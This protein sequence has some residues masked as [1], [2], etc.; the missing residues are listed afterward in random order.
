MLLS[1]CHSEYIQH[2]VKVSV[3]LS[4]MA[5]AHFLNVSVDGRIGYVTRISLLGPVRER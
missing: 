3:N 2:S 5:Y 4:Q 1:Q